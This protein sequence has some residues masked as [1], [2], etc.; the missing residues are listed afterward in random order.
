M[1]EKGSQG[2]DVSSRQKTRQA[3]HKSEPRSSRCG[4]AET[5][6][7]R[8]HKVASSIPGLAQRVKDLALP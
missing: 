6:L 5:H 8:N 1:K 3:T 2:R 4:T 7:T